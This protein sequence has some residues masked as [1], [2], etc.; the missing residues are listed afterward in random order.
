M[1]WVSYVR[2]EWDY[3]GIGLD[4]SLC[5]GMRCLRYQNFTKVAPWV[6][7]HPVR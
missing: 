6:V 3:I 5:I 7:R 1:V 4:W 2:L